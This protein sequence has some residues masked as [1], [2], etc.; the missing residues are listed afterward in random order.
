MFSD[1]YPR[2]DRIHRG[3]YARRRCALAYYARLRIFV[4]ADLYGCTLPIGVRPGWLS[5][6]DH[7]VLIFGAIA[8]ASPL[9]FFVPP[10][11]DIVRTFGERR[12][13]EPFYSRSVRALVSFVAAAH[14]IY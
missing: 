6:R 10:Y 2:I 5:K 4:G 7:A 13:Y 12:L 14:F 8:G 9:I 3:V 1:I 11:L